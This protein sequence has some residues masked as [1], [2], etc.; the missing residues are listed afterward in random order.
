MTWTCPYCGAELEDV[1]DYCL[2][3]HRGTVKCCVVHYRYGAPHVHVVL[4]TRRGVLS[5][6]R[7]TSYLHL[8]TRTEHGYR[9]SLR[10]LVYQ[11]FEY[12]LRKRPEIIVLSTDSTDFRDEFLYLSH[13]PVDLVRSTDLSEV[14]R[15][16]EVR[17]CRELV[18]RTVDLRP[19]EKIS[20]AHTTIIGGEEA[21]QLLRRIAECPYVK[22]IVPG[23]IEAKGSAGRGGLRI[24]V[25]RVD[26]R[27]NLK[28]T[29]THGSAKQD[30]YV[31]TVAS[32]S[33]EGEVIAREIEKIV[34]EYLR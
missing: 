23:R 16:A 4:L 11:V 5:D 12:V 14:V 20:G 9:V 33:Y 18:L 30:I 1:G 29:L 25:T 34:R 26:E 10:N 28:L 17:Y 7:I 27:G 6:R 22:K 15:Y 8:Y 13:V 24:H 32:N 19:E 3:C 2:Y 31:V 21:L